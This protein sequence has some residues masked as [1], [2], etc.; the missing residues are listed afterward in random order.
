MTMAS[1][2]EWLRRNELLVLC[3]EGLVDHASWLLPDRFSSMEA[4]I[5]LLRSVS[6]AFSA[7]NAHMLSSSTSG[8]GSSNFL[9]SIVSQVCPK[10][11]ELI[12]KVHS[13]HSLRDTEIWLANRQV[14][15]L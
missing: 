13:Q 6:G 4:P 10:R 7:L 3:L 9:L 15:H 14:M 8:G 11:A 12:Q 2:R 1:Y 5:E